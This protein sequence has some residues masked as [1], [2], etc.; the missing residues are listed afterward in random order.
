[1]I[2]MNFIVEFLAT[3]PDGGYYT[4]I[5]NTTE[6]TKSIIKYLKEKMWLDQFTKAAFVE[7]NLYN[8]NSEFFTNGILIAESSSTGT[9]IVVR[10]IV[11]SN[12]TL[13]VVPKYAFEYM[14]NN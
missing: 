9:S 3:Y 7:I 12:Y 14:K 10:A 13:L 11:S 4:G 8:P 1:M 5:G 2:K 6:S